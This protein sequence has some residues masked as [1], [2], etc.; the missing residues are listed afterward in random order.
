MWKWTLV[1]VRTGSEWVE[2]AGLIVMVLAIGTSLA[3][4]LEVFLTKQ[5]HVKDNFASNF[6]IARS[7]VATC[8]GER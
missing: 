6:R 4:S 5:T 1:S 7:A 3:L 8:R 2:L